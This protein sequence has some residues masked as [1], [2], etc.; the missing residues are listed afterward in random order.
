MAAAGFILAPLA[1][2]ASFPCDMA[3]Q[4]I[5][6]TICSSSETSDLDEYLGRY[7]AAARGVFRHAEACLVSDQRAWLRTVRDA[8]KDTACLKRTYLDRLAV[9]HAIQPGATSLRNV[10][11]PKVPPLVWIVPPASDQVAA[12]RNRATTPLVAS[13]RIVDEIAS[14]DGIVLKSNAGEKVLIVPSMFLEQSTTDALTV[15][16]RLPNATYEVRGRTETQAQPVKA[17]ATGQCAFVYRT[18]P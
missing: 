2:A 16:G 17:F 5:E 7:Y 3:K 10:D 18:A 13:G 8:C 9:L 6:K 11:L 15:L 1:G 12:P 14:G 4:A